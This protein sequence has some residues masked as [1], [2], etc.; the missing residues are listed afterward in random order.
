[1]SNRHYGL[2]ILRICR[3]RQKNSENFGFVLRSCGH[4]FTQELTT[5]LEA[6]RSENST[7]EPVPDQSS[8]QEFPEENSTQAK[9]VSGGWVGRGMES[10]WGCS[11]ATGW[12]NPDLAQ[13]LNT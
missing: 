11:L 5:S 7:P 8:G 9:K 1:M 3:L 4:Q 13:F 12:R 6:S 2:L 10:G